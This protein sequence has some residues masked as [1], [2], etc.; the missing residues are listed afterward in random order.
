MK[1]KGL[2]V[3]R[4]EVVALPDGVYEGLWSGYEVH[5]L[6]QTGYFVLHTKDG[7]RGIDI[8]VKVLVSGGV[9]TIE[10]VE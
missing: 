6:E 10:T 1:T 2:Y 8:P 5:L 7:V 9:I 3:E 4:V